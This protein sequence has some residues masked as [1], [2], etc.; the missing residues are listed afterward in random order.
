L[1]HLVNRDERKKGKKKRRKYDTE[2]KQ[3]VLLMIA[4]G[5]TAREEV[6]ESLGMVEKLIYRWRSRQESEGTENAGATI[7]QSSLLQRIRKL[8]LNMDSMLRVRQKLKDR[9]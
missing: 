6:A 3:Q 1:L 2:F 7:D 4:N 8:E 5:R 9:I